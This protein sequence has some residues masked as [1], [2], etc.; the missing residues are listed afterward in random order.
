MAKKYIVYERY[1]FGV[2]YYNSAMQAIPD[3]HI[4]DGQI[5]VV[6]ENEMKVL[7]ERY[8]NLQVKEA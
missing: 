1:M 5:P 6:N 7:V 4:K 2:N 3:Y 8:P